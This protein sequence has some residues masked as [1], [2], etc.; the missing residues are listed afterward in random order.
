MDYWLSTEVQT[1]VAEALVDSPA[2]AEVVVSDEIADNLTYG[3]DLIN[4]LNLLSPAVIIDNREAWVEQ[5]NTEVI[6]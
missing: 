2:N 4:S 6:Q 3:A 5:W 1:K